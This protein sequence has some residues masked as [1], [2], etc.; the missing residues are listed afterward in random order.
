LG[1]RIETTVPGV[2]K[3][4]VRPGWP[5]EP[6][7][8]RKRQQQEPDRHAG[9]TLRTS[10]SFIIRLAGFAMAAI[11]AGM[12]IVLMW[13]DFA[14]HMHDAKTYRHLALVILGAIEILSV[15]IW[16]FWWLSEW[17][18]PVMPRPEAE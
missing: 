7:R 16:P 6:N 1:S 2:I 17:L 13:P 4:N 10:L 5:I 12:W 14:S 15:V 8:R 3:E 18:N 11:L 9:Y